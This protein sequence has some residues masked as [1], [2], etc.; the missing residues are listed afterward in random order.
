MKLTLTL[1]LS[2]VLVRFSVPGPGSWTLLSKDP[3]GYVSRV[4]SSG[5]SLEPEHICWH[6]AR[7]NAA[8]VFVVEWRPHAI[9]K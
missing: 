6:G 8:R 7:T 1:A 4:E 9:K 3:G 5:Y 2:A